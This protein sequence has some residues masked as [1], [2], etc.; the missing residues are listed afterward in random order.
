MHQRLIPRLVNI[1]GCG[2][3]SMKHNNVAQFICDI[4][5]HCRSFRQSDMAERGKSYDSSQLLLTALEDEE[6]THALLEIILTNLSEESTAVA[7]IK[8]IL[9]LLEK[10][11]ILM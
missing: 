5:T 6:I 7:G 1:L 9:K 10:P 2:A 11:Q 4:V 3:E 8:I